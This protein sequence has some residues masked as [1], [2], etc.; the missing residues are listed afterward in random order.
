[1][2]TD[3]VYLLSLRQQ[4]NA[5]QLVNVLAIRCKTSTEPTT[6]SFT[7][8]ATS[9]ANNLQDFQV[10][11]VSYTDWRALKV[12]GTGV[13]YNTT[14]P[15]RVSTVAFA[16]PYT[17]TITGVL[18][19]A[20]AAMQCSWLIGLNTSQA[21]RRRRGRLFVGGVT[22]A[23]ITDGGVMSTSEVSATQ[24]VMNSLVTVYGS[25]GSDTNFE[26]GV[27]SDRIAM[28]V[29]YNNAWPR[30]LVTQGAPDPDNAYLAITSCTVKTLV[31]SQR[32]RRPGIGS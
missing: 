4:M 16:G 25:G 11:D 28:N 9:F 32:D 12:R 30:E 3:D 5:Q 2:A 10:D 26:W 31:G 29:A 15:F 14:A 8:L 21:G 19:G 18:T 7:A 1:M 24:T 22:E 13:T 23:A 6:A 27:W 17:G 20:P